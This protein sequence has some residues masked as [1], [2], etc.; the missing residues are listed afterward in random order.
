[1]SRCTIDGIAIVR[2]NWL[3]KG[4]EVCG[5]GQTKPDAW[6]DAAERFGGRMDGREMIVRHP[7]MKSVEARITITFDRPEVSQ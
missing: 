2:K 3:G 7:E 5:I 1:M 6:R 4:F